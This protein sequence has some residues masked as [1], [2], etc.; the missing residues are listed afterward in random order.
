MGSHTGRSCWMALFAVTVVLVSPLRREAFASAVDMIYS[1]SD[2]GPYYNF[3]IYLTWDS[4][5]TSDYI[6][7]GFQFGFQ[8][9]PGG[10]MGTQLIGTTKKAIFSIWDTTDGSGTAQPKSSWCT[11]FSGEGTGAHCDINFSWVVGRQYQLR[12]WVLD[13]DATGTNWGAWITDTVTQAGSFIGEIHLAS[14]NGYTG[15]GWLVPYNIFTFL[16]YFSGS[17]CA[18]VVNYAKVYWMGPIGRAP[19]NQPFTASSATISNYD[20][21]TMNATTPQGYP[22]VALEAGSGVRH[23]NAVGTRLW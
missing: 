17:T 19:S 20:C 7:P 1:F 23:T 12:L 11:R 4:A 10:Y 8:A 22:T 9:G 13:S 18:Q 14:S 21:T 16:E 3:D 15:Y 5:P 2:P 6:Y